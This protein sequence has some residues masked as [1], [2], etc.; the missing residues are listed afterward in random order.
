MQKGGY[1]GQLGEDCRSVSKVERWAGAD[2]TELH[3]DQQHAISSRN[4]AMKTSVRST[5]CRASSSIFGV[6][7]IVP[8]CVVC[9]GLLF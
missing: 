4:S 2:A 3:L 5:C 1:P 8:F 7:L 6:G 9:R